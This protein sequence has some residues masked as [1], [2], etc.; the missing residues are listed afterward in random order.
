M[1]DNYS[2]AEPR[3]VS[4]QATRDEIL[5][6]FARRQ[7]AWE[8]LD[9]AALA[10]DC[11]EDC[12]VESPMSGT[13][14]GRTAIERALRAAFDAFLDLK[15]TTESLLIDGNQVVQVMS[16]EGT[17]IG[18]FM[19][20]APSGKPFKL[21]VVFLYELDGC[22]IVRERRIYDFTSLLMQIGILKAKPT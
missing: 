14:R 12:T 1:R 19:G 7:E 6:L 5:S 17:D 11:S 4:R 13:H 10:S 22:Q 9:A 16:S 20:L 15:T 21:L 3:Q 8:N 18:G 2:K